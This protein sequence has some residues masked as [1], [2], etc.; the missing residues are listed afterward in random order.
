MRIDFRR[1]HAG[2]AE[3]LLDGEQVGTAFEQMCGKTVPES[4]RTDGFGDAVSFRQVLDNQ[5]NHLARQ[6]RA[7]AVEENGVGEFEFRSN[8]QPCAFNVLEQ[9]FQA[10]VADGYE[11]FLAALA[12]DAEEAIVSVNI[13]DLQSDE[14]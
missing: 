14:F 3:H 4:M 13:A 10:A 11:P 12:N 6:S 5:E 1:A 7:T 8:M 9:D 2:V